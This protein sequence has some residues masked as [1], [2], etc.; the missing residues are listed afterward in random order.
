LAGIPG[1]PFTVE[2]VNTG[3]NAAVLGAG[4]TLTHGGSLALFVDYNA[5]LRNHETVHAV[6]G[7]LRVVW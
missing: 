6:V 4:V 5:E 1:L 7:G 3:H 2:G